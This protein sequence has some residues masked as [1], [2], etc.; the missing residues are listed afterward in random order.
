MKEKDEWL[1]EVQLIDTGEMILVDKK[2]L[3]EY[4]QNMMTVK[5][6]GNRTCEMIDVNPIEDEINYSEIVEEYTTSESLF[7]KI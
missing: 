6:W 2:E 5:W 1:V 3:E 7:N 4:M